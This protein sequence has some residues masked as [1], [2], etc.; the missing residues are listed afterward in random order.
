MELHIPFMS[1]LD[2][3]FIQIAS[4]RDPQLFPTITDCLKK[5]AHPD[6]LRFGVCWQHD[7]TEN[8]DLFKNDKRFQILKYHWSKSRGVCWARSLTQSLYNGE[9]YTLQIDSHMRFY[10]NWDELL[11]EMLSETESQKPLLTAYPAP[12]DPN[13][14]TILP[15]TPHKIVINYFTPEGSISSRPEPIPDS[16][17]GDKPLRASFV[18]AGFFFTLGQH[19]QECCYDPQMYFSQEETSLSVR[20]FTL[21]YDFFH[22]HINVLW[23][24][25]TREGKPKHWEDHNCQ[26][27]EVKKIVKTWGEINTKANQRMRQLLQQEDTGIDL[28]IFGLGTQRSLAEYEHFSGLDFKNKRIQSHTLLGNEPP[29][30]YSS[31]DLWEIGFAKEYTISAFWE[32]EKIETAD[33]YSFW[34][35]GIEDEKGLVLYRED[36]S[37]NRLNNFLHDKTN[38]LT[39]KFLSATTPQKWILW[40]V[41]KSRGWLQRIE[42]II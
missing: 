3:I 32:F 17:L 26:Q 25:Y 37:G 27:N 40:P 36:I 11:I 6:R 19:C 42:G 24:E 34:Y 35:F 28:G 2:T 13:N 38:S 22:P 23:H 7:E 41:S 33:D 15:N 30:P 14:E 16:Q 29:V 1:P 18:A 12:F 21:G 4:Y 39:I 9:T 10:P 5:A 31:K 20:S 8:L